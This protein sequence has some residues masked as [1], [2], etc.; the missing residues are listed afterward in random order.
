MRNGK[1]SKQVDTAD[2]DRFLMALA[3]GMG[4]HNN[5][6]IASAEALSNLRFFFSDLP[7]ALDPEQFSQFM[8]QWLGSINH[9]FVSKGLAD[10]SCHDM[11]TT[12]VGLAYY[13]H[14]FFSMNCGDS[15]LYRLR[16]G[17]MEQLTTDH[18]LSN[19]LGMDKHTSLIT[20]CI[21]AGCKHSF[22]DIGVIST[23]PGDEKTLQPGDSI[24]LCSD[25]L[26]D[27]ISDEEIASIITQG[28]DADALCQA[29]EDAGG[30]DNISAI[31]ARIS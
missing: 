11:G 25:G 7:T 22:I 23:T 6:E 1:M 24:L 17:K 9:I 27:M 5:G 10:Q 19:R 2:T 13:D 28:F 15:R 8:K 12:L 4:G 14:H 18:S 29:A 3:D 30:Y 20:N 31:V 21:G 16:D 26:T